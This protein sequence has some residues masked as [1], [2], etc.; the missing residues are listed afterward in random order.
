MFYIYES[1]RVNYN[2]AFFMGIKRINSIAGIGFP[3]P[4]KFVR[5]I[6]NT[7]E[8][9]LNKF[10]IIEDGE[11]FVN[12]VP[13][14]YNKTGMGGNIAKPSYSYQIEVELKRKTIENKQK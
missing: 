13:I 4:E 1:N 6:K 8:D 5:I 12:V 9:N 14:E 10:S 7:V 11:F 2:D 3:I